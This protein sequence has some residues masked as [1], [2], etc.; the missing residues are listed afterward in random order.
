MA[1]GPAVALLSGGLD[2]LTALAWALEHGCAK[3]ALSHSYGQRYAHEID[4]ITAIADH[5]GVHLINGRL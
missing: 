3:T 4:V 2:S 1:K 5:Y